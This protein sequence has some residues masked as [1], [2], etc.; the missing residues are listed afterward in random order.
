MKKLGTAKI[1]DFFLGFLEGR[2]RKNRCECFLFTLS[3]SKTERLAN[4]KL[5]I[6]IN[7]ALFLLDT[8]QYIRNFF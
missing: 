1:F 7:R 3:I 5:I 8:V 2:G 4:R 6:V